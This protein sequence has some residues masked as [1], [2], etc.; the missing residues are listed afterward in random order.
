M[1]NVNGFL[2]KEII[3][4]RRGIIGGRKINNY[5]VIWYCFI[6]FFF[7]SREDTGCLRNFR[8]VLL[9]SL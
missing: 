4:Y 8:V 1:K 7:L 5:G 6:F 2:R 3:I 9:D